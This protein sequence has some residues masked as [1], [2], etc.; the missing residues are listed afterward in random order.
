MKKKPQTGSS[1]AELG[2]RL[3]CE[4][5][6]Q[7]CPGC[8]SLCLFLIVLTT[9]VRHTSECKS[10]PTFTRRGAGKRSL[11]SLPQ[12]ETLAG[13]CMTSQTHGEQPWTATTSCLCLFLLHLIL[14]PCRPGP[15]PPRSTNDDEDLIST[16]VCH[17][18]K[19][20]SHAQQKQQNQ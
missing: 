12:K 17:T 5:F 18:R 3:N 14:I 9:R 19:G 16:A 15:G 6:W 13:R 20:I 8:R 2:P 1:I 10:H 11:Y 7:A 4:P